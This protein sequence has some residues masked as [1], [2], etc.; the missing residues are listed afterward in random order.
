MTN[1]PYRSEI[2]YTI[3]VSNPTGVDAN[4][5]LFTNT[6]PSTVDFVRWIESPANVSSLAAGNITWNGSLAAAQAITFSYVVTHTGDYGDV[7]DNIVE[8]YHPQSLS[9][10][11]YTLTVTIEDKPNL[12]VFVPIVL[13]RTQ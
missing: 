12:F 3:V 9:T 6:L 13:K 10:N 5:V 1:A 7:L 4:N 11:S 8:L 2:T